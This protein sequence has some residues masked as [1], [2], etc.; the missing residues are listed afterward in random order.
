MSFASDRYRFI[1]IH[2]PKTG[3]RSI[4][5]LLKKFC[6][7]EIVFTTK[8]LD[9]NVNVLGR[10]IA[11][12][13][14]TVI[15]KD[16]WNNYLKAAFVRNPWDRTV[17]VYEHFKQSY[18]QPVD[19]PGHYNDNSAKA[20]WTATILERLQIP[21]ETF[22]FEVFVKKVIRDR[23]FDNYHWDTQLN[24]ISDEENEV[25]MD[26]IGRFENLHHDFETICKK[27]NIPP[28]TLPHYN[29]TQR[30][31]YKTYYTPELRKVIENAYIADIETFKY[32]F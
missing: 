18:L 32:K 26:F 7:P 19:N 13:A 27:V 21:I 29:K 3:G 25:I 20:N 12:E 16:K 1:F 30:R 23:V 11:L 15:P 17:S 6:E 10:K 2:V 31:N 8:K 28:L 22:T 14:Q 24:V 9:E 4:N 5:K